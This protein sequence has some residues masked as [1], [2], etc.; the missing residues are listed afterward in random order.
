[1]WGRLF[2]E[3]VAMAAAGVQV[4][5]QEVR[6]CGCGHRLCSSEYVLTVS[7]VSLLMHPMHC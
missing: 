7:D 2:V 1:V 4:H 6:L 3:H 5:Y